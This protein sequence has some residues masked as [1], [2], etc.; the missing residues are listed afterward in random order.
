MKSVESIAMCTA[1]VSKKRNVEAEDS[2]SLVT[3]IECCEANI[4]IIH[5][6]GWGHIWCGSLAPQILAVA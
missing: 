6:L 2:V 5:R 3:W 1:A 4:D